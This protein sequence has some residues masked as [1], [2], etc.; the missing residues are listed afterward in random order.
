MNHIHYP[1]GSYVPAYGEDIAITPEIRW[2]RMP[3]P[4]VLNH[5]NIWLINDNH[6]WTCIDTGVTWENGK[7]IWEKR[8]STYPLIRQIITHSHPDHIGLS[9]W[10]QQKTE[11][12]LWI[13]QSEYLTALAHI[14]QIGNYTIAA[15]CSLFKKHGLDN[16]RLN[17]LK[18]R[19]NAMKTGCPILPQTYQAIRENDIILIGEHTWEVITGFGHAYEHAALF[20][21]DLKILISGDMLLPSIS[22]N[23][24]VSAFCPNGNPLKDFLDSLQKFRKLPPDTLVLPSHGRPFLGINERIDFLEFHHKERLKL[25]LKHCSKP[26]I[27]CA[28]MPKLFNR[29]ITDA[30]QCQFAMGEAIAHLNYL[31][32][33]NQ[34]ERLNQNGIFYYHR[35]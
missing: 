27:A 23:V 34:V 1:L 17:A 21:A 7:A 29:E 3:L 4:F 18:K 14:N 8:L 6:G 13:T 33:L 26:K 9:G 25:I 28:I 19:G 11:A 15:M 20:C 5:V 24:P 2:L 12:P 22:T 31:E 10:L 32:Q 35:K 16:V 30:H